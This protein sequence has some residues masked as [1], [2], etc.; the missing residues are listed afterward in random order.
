[1]ETTPKEI[2]SYVTREKKVP[3][4]EWFYSLADEQTQA[5]IDARIARLRLGLIGHA[6]G[7]GGGVQELKIDFGPGYRVYFGQEGETLVILLC[8]GSKRTQRQ[9]IKQAKEYWQD[10]QARAAAARKEREE[11]K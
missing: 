7:V 6:R 5:V 4:R 2:R 8:G 9:D 10:Y 3:F 11:K 1:M